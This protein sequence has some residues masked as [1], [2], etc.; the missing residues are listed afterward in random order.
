MIFDFTVKPELLQASEKK[1]VIFSEKENKIIKLK[2]NPGLLFE[3]FAEFGK[4]FDLG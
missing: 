3:I 2:E 4:E 1:A